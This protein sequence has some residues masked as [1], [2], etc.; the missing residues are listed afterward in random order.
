M[1]R[2]KRDLNQ[3]DIDRYL[4]KLISKREADIEAIYAE[5]LQRIRAELFLVFDTASGREK[6]ELTRAELA[7]YSVLRQTKDNI[8]EYLVKADEKAYRVAQTTLEEQAL[9]NFYRSSYL[10]EAS[11]GAFGGVSADVIQAVLDNPYTKIKLSSLSEKNQALTRERIRRILGVELTMGNTYD[12]IAQRLRAEVGFSRYR[13]QTVARTEGHRAQ[14][15]GR[16]RAVEEQRRKGRAMEKIWIATL[17]MVTRDAHQ[18]LD[19]TRLP[20]EE[21]FRSDNG[22][23]GPQPGEM[24]E[25]ADD[26]NCRCT[27]IYTVNGRL[28]TVRFARDAAGQSSQIAFKTYAEW[29]KEQAA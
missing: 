7:R 19:G 18:E 20:L 14:I 12:D 28:P 16:R 3:N 17:D 2:N 21:Y 29:R 26:I 8:V 1:A 10:Y 4:D 13:A 24:D 6:M 11:M 27:L 23:Y 25:A 5:A 9:E 15:E 22:G